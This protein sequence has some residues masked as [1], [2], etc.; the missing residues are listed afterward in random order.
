VAD[1]AHTV[2]GGGIVFATYRRIDLA[3]AHA[4][5]LTGTDVVTV[6]LD[7]VAPE[8]RACIEI[9][10]ALPPEIREDM[11]TDWEQDDDVT[12]PIETEPTPLLVDDIDNQ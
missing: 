7:T 5:C 2:M 3:I 12:P 11:Q 1:I 8:I 9:L 10:D 6:D 4:R